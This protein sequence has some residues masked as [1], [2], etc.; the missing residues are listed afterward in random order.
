MSQE[1]P[2]Q[3]SLHV[4]TPEDDANGHFP[5][6]RALWRAYFLAP[7][8][9][10]IAFVVIV[11]LVGLIAP[12][13]GADVNPA[14]MIV[15]PVIALTVGF[16]SCYLIAGVFGMPIAFYLRRRR[17]LNGYSIHGAALGWAVL[18]SVFCAF[19][20]VGSDQSEFPLALGYFGMGVIPPILLS[21]TA[22][23]YLLNRFS[24]SE[25]KA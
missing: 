1:N 20:M 18:F 21:G 4:T 17:F 11:F 6:S 14:S 5:S 24:R 3:S 9:A 16:V 13:L 2:Y 12:N 25:A 15:L 8:V 23:W 22:F 19:V 10:P 7:A